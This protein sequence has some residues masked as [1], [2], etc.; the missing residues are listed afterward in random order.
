MTG[1]GQANVQARLNQCYER[2][3]E[4]GLLDGSYGTHNQLL[5]WWLSFGLF[6]VVLYVIYFGTLWST[7]WQR[8]DAGHRGCIIRILLCCVT[9]NVLTRQWGIVLFTSFNALFLSGSQPEP[10]IAR[11]SA[12]R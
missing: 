4:P 6:G 5:H 8:K 12:P 11:G 1:I 2:F 3:G 7:A 9:E 10:P